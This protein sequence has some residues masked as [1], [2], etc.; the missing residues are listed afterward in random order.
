MYFN[1]SYV[2]FFVKFL[3]ITFNETFVS[4]NYDVDSI[5][6]VLSFTHLANGCFS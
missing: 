6:L 2:D 5:N 3:M 4:V 1:L